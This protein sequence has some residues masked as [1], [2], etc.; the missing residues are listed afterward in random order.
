LQA[1]ADL[2]RRRRRRR[3]NEEGGGELSR[4]SRTT[5]GGD[6]HRI[7]QLNFMPAAAKISFDLQAGRRA[8][9]PAGH[10]SPRNLSS[11]GNPFFF[12]FCVF[13]P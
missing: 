3:R 8:S 1:A 6:S 11:V 10:E 12:A 13:F 2:L 5:A 4:K 7:S 9:S